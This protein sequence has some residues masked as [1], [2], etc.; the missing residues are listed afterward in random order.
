MF[1]NIFNIAKANIKGG[2]KYPKINGAVTFREVKNGVLVTAKVNVL[3]QSSDSCTGR[4]F[5]F[6]IHEGSSCSGTI[7]D[8]FANAKTHL[9]P[10]NCPHPFHMGDLPPLIENNG[11]AHMTVLINK[12]KI[13][14]IL[15]KVVIIHDSPDDFTTQP[16]GN[17]GSKIA[18]GIIE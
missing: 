8:E 10:T 9:N 16:S 15:G 11:Y 3:P 12:F 7:S 14:D 13:K 18:C 4:F 17:S 6:H 1:T 5:G 2:K